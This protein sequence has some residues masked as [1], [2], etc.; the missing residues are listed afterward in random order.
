[1]AQ[2]TQSTLKHYLALYKKAP[3][4]RIFAPLADIYR[5]KGH[6]D[7]ALSLCQKG[8]KLF[9]DFALGHIILGMV[10]LDLNKLHLA[11]QALEKAIELSPK[12]LLAHKLLGQIWLKQRNPENTLS[13]YKNI[14]LLDPDNKK[15]QRIV[16]KLSMAKAVQ[17]D[18]T[19]FTFK[20]TTEVSQYLSPPSPKVP[21]TI[22]PL[23]K[24]ESLKEK[25]EWE[26]RLSII[27]SLMHKKDFKKAQE[28]LIEVKNIY[29][30]G[31][32]KTHI[33]QLEEQLNA[34][35]SRSNTAQD[36]TSV[37][38]TQVQLTQQQTKRKQQ[39]KQLQTLL[40]HINQHLSQQPKVL[41][42][43]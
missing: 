34:V 35:L 32:I 22:H 16:Q 36:S 21:P 25:N 30:E 39:I 14:L 29:K 10:L 8:I 2:V 4:S 13:T 1:M 6:L 12:S 26:S 18:D 5:H 3:N 24:V 42:K 27:K 41:N 31:T 11:T 37:F 7:K 20:T 43:W 19:G 15:A 17:T 23:P 9:P 33:Q 38:K 28:L 40:N